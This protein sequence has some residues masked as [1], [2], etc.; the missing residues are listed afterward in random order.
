[1]KKRII[2]LLLSAVMLL[3]AFP[4][5]VISTAAD[6]PETV[7]LLINYVYASTGALVERQYKAQML[8]GSNFTRSITI[9]EIKSGDK[10]TYYAPEGSYEVSA[11]NGDGVAE[12]S[13]DGLDFTTVDI[14]SGASS[15]KGIKTIELALTE[16]AGDIEITIYYIAARASYTVQH[17][18][19]NLGD[20]DYVLDSS[21]TA[22]L[23]GDIEAYTQAVASTAKAGY[24]C[25]GVPENEIA[26]D[27]STVINL[28][29]N[30]YGYTIVFDT[31]G[32]YNGP[33]PYYGKYGTKIDP[34]TFVTPTRPKYD[35]AGWAPNPVGPDGKITITG[36]VTYQAQWTPLVDHPKFTVVLWGQNANDD[37]YSYLGAYK[38]AYGTAGDT[39]TYTAA[40]AS[41]IYICPEAHTHTEA[42]YNRTCG[43]EAHV[44]TLDCGLNC[45]HV[46]TAAC[47]GGTS[48]VNPADNA[49]NVITGFS[50][51][52]ASGSFNGGLQEGYIYE[53]NC[54]GA[55]HGHHYYL[56]FGG[57]WY[58]SS[59]SH[60]DGAA[61]VSLQYKAGSHLISSNRD[62]LKVYKA[63]LSSCTHTA[64]TDACYACGK[65]V[66]THSA[67]GGTCY[68]LICGKASHTHTS[69]CKKLSDT[70]SSMT[71][72][73]NAGRYVFSH[74]DTIKID[75][76]GTSV[77]NVYFNRTEYTI[78]F[79]DGGTTVKTLKARWGKD[80]SDQ[81]P[82]VGVKSGSPITYDNGERWDPSGSSTYRE[83]LVTINAMP[84]ESFTLTK[85]TASYTAYTM[86]YYG[87]ALP[88][89][90]DTVT[91]TGSSMKYSLLFSVKA[92]YNYI[93]KAEDFL[94][95]VGFTQETSDPAF[96][97]GQASPGDR[98]MDFY[99]TRNSHKLF[100]YSENDSVPERE[101]D[102]KF[103]MPLTSYYYD[104]S[105]AN[106]PVRPLATNPVTGTF[107]GW[108]ANPEHSG[109]PFDFSSKMPDD[110]VALYAWWVDGLFK[111]ETFNTKDCTDGDYYTY[112]GYPGYEENIIMYQP[113]DP[114]TD[115]SKIYQ[116]FIGWY[117]HDDV[118]DIE[119]PFDYTLP[120]THDYKLYPKYSDKV[121]V[122]YTV[123]Y[124][125]E[126]TTT[127]VAEDKVGYEFIGLNVTEKCKIGAQL[128][129]VEDN[130]LTYFPITVSHGISLATDHEE[131]AFYYKKASDVPYTV[132][133]E[134]Y[135]GNTLLPSVEKKTDY[136]VVVEKYEEIDGY[137]PTQYRAS[138]DVTLDGKTVYTFLYSSDAS[139]V[140]YEY[141]GTVPAGAPDAPEQEN[142]PTGVEVTVKTAPTM[143]GYTFSGWTTDTA[144]V[145]DGK[146]TMNSSEVK[147]TGYWTVNP[148]T[149]TYYVDGEVYN[150]TLD[151]NVANY[152]YGET[153]ASVSP[154]KTNYDFDGW[155]TDS[156]MKLKWTNP[157][158]MPDT[159]L[160]LYGR[161]VEQTASIKITMD[162]ME[163]TENA[164]FIIKGDGLGD[165]LRVVV[166]G[167]DGETVIS[168]FPLG[169]EYTI[170]M[171]TEWT[172]AYDQKDDKVSQKITPTV[173]DK[174][175]EAAFVN[176]AKGTS[177]WLTS[178][179]AK[180][181]VFGKNS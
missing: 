46:H 25:T 77:L 134:D 128:N 132:K 158:T 107:M 167:N 154:T 10:T 62:T 163:S 14:Q 6:E 48:T 99:Y 74:S 153:I 81:F 26:S 27:G 109:T 49:S 176:V 140:T 166:N 13:L 51:L 87:E 93:T 21:M 97:G 17:W 63:K 72:G 41:S 116:V 144:V 122:P 1:M 90:T 83:V 152:N 56:Y 148:H 59:S 147:F 30:R 105:D 117:Y 181:N 92:K 66:H 15:V 110:N 47:Y 156:D 70:V 23:E 32:G 143:T 149:I 36:N 151:S 55:A 82:V 8:K 50:S 34:S 3:T 127:K 24:Y 57:K 94:N 91:R 42:C 2:S 71:S 84:A 29:Y 44:H 11:I 104:Q 145:K 124:Y 76:A 7:D 18:F 60:T 164:V 85:D 173:K 5:G 39:I 40:L 177:S 139:P 100:F 98:I 96:S 28:Y 20:D 172:P 101:Y 169:V 121:L 108:Y 33:D 9:P 174:V 19:Q 130:P 88:G 119:R 35:F 141:T 142:Y 54:D 69:S 106:P 102:V 103:N 138:I 165:G 157:G 161:F 113:A 120:I 160:T 89:A 135:E 86:N 65:A 125:L 16:I 175:Y 112:D 162:G 129:M 123:H 78:T 178:E 52:P 111:V 180:K 45:T 75:A 79:K 171:E 37:G 80:I 126:G 131:Y 67:I 115:P 31:N 68:T 179:I 146:F 22:T 133:Y 12:T 155:Y 150:V 114:P 136:A 64:H 137:I 61:I 95:I 168:G 58:S 118:Y 38:D 4:L 159:D 170:E 73:T 43:L 53:I